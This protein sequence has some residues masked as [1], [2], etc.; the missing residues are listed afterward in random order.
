MVNTATLSK[1]YSEIKNYSTIIHHLLQTK[2]T[3]GLLNKSCHRKI[4]KSRSFDFAKTV[5]GCCCSE[6]EQHII[7]IKTQELVAL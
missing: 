6:K 2:I 4:I 1:R 7:E 3:A 5:A